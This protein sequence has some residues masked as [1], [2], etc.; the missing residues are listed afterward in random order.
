MIEQPLGR[1][2]IFNRRTSG[3]PFTNSEREQAKPAPALIAKANDIFLLAAKTMDTE[4]SGVEEE[5]PVW[6]ENG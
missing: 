1:A 3:L 4:V 6:I 5:P 2:A